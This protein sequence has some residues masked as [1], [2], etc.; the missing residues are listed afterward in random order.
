MIVY[1]LYA[2]YNDFDAVGSFDWVALA[3]L[4]TLVICTVLYKVIRKRSM[5]PIATILL[6]AALGMLYFI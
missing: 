3:I 1:C 5:P 6:S 2:Q 4:V